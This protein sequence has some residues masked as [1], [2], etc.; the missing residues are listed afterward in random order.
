MDLK[1]IFSKDISIYETWRLC[2]A[3]H[4][5]LPAIEYFGNQTTFKQTDEMIDVYARAFMSLLPDRT[6]SVTFCVPTLPS[7]LFA[8]YALNKIGIRANFV[9]HTILPS[10]PKEYIDESDTE[11]LV[12]FDGFFSTVTEGIAGTSLRKIVITS[13]ADGV[14]T[15]PDYVPEQVR[16]LLHKSNSAQKIQ[17]AMPHMNVISLDDFVAIGE[18]STVAV[19]S[20]YNKGETAVVLYTGGSTGIP[21]GVEKTNEEFTAM[22][23]IYTQVDYFGLKAGERFLVIAPPNHPTVFVHC[24]VLP[25]LIGVTK[26]LQPIYDKYTF[27]HDLFY[28]KAKSVMA[29]PSHYAVLPACEF[30]NGALSHLNTAFCGGE[31]V[32]VELAVSVNKALERLG[33]KN[34]YLLIGYGMSEIGPLT[35]IPVG[36]L[37]L[38]NKVGKPLPGVVS[39]IVDD[40]GCIQGDNIRGNLEIKSPCR[41]KGYFK[42]P[43][44][45]KAFFTEDGFAKTGDIAIRDENGYYDVL[46]RASD[47]IVA[48]D[49]SIVY[50][51]D[52][53]R[54]VYKDIA[55]LECEVTGLEADGA[56]VPVVHIVLNAEYTGKVEETILRIH[57]LCREHLSEN[58]MPHGYKVREAFGTN[59]ISQKRDYKALEL[60]RDG[61][62]MPDGDRLRDVSF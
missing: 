30:P 11:V 14:D 59:P 5:D 36:V 10:N 27:A 51:F 2:N 24:I 44:L 34:P 37:N 54:V 35:H 1:E 3:E 18:Q 61:F 53:E 43:E 16:A 50:L 57:N 55:V 40:K 47:S 15:V 28:L 23:R 38:Q 25:W 46:G 49:G 45:T 26:V 56:K 6:K 9:S 17:A 7:T 48:H 32:S 33:V 52:I 62:L 31:A 41:M 4:P 60:E 39:R 8:F 20:I 21:K 42:Q 13:L 19:D 22:L 12:L 58:E 29:A